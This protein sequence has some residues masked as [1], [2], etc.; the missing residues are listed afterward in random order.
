V[1]PNFAAAVK[2]P[3]STARTNAAKPWSWVLSIVAF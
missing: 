3:A 1:P 2:E